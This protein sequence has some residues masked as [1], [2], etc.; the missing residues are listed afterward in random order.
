MSLERQTRCQVEEEVALSDQSE[1]E[2]AGHPRVWAAYP[3]PQAPL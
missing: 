2:E 1:G 3:C